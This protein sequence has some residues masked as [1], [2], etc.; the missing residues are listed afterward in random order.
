MV[1]EGYIVS[2]LLVWIEYTEHIY[3]SIFFI[4]Y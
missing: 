1:E 4:S 3:D 2:S